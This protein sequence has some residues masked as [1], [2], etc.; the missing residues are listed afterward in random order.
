[1]TGV[2]ENYQTTKLERKRT[3]N[4]VSLS[5]KGLESIQNTY[6]AG[7]III[8]QCTWKLVICIFFLSDLL[9]LMNAY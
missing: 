4:K 9:I 1:M 8:M 3:N 7:K 5:T 6:T 2:P